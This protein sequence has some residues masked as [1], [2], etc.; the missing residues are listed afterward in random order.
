MS[1]ILFTLS[2]PVSMVVVTLSMGGDPMTTPTLTIG[3]DYSST[4]QAG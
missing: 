3:V 4:R 2:S 1:T